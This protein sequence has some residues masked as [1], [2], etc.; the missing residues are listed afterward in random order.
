MHAEAQLNANANFMHPYLLSLDSIANALHSFVTN[1]YLIKKS[2]L[3]NN[4]TVFNY[5]VNSIDSVNEL[6]NHLHDYCNNLR[7][8]NGLANYLIFSKM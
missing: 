1:K 2:A 6:F 8:F 3:I 4:N 7:Q 5:H